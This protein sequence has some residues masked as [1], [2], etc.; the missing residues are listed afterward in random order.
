MKKTIAN[1]K[2]RWPQLHKSRL[3]VLYRTVRVATEF[4]NLPIASILSSSYVNQLEGTDLAFD[5]AATSGIKSVSD[6]QGTNVAKVTV[7]GK[8][9]APLDEMA[10]SASA[11]KVLKDLVSNLDEVASND[12]ISGIASIARGLLDHLNQ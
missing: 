3:L 9:V 12:D 2:M 8:A 4:T 7:G 6:E 1:C 10:S 11:F 5:A